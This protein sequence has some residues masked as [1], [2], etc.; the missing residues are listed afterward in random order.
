[1][2][3]REEGVKRWEAPCKCWK[4]GGRW[5]EPHSPLPRNDHLRDS[6][7][8]GGQAPLALSP[9]SRGSGTHSPSALDGEGRLW[10]P[11]PMFQNLAPL[12]S[13][14]RPPGGLSRH[15]QPLL[16]WGPRA[17]RGWG[18]RAPGGEDRRGQ[19]KPP[20]W[21]ARGA[22]PPGRTQQAE[23]QEQGPAIR[24]GLGARQGLGAAVW[25]WTW[26][27]CG[28]QGAEDKEERDERHRPSLRHRPEPSAGHAHA[29][30][31]RPTLVRRGLR[32]ASS[33]SNFPAPPSLAASAPRQAPPRG[34][35]RPSLS[36]APCSRWEPPR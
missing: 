3:G 20:A 1:M 25:G 7:L 17:G 27:T 4:E 15:I 18:A 6:A 14:P 34:K 5:D 2:C 26:V 36:S 19:G 11:G 24:A 30:K 33:G 31:P 16:T 35:P 9:T 8:P 32:P 28:R 12:P 23:A 29:R 21:R 13:R 10:R 22:L